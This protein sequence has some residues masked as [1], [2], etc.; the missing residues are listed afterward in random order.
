MVDR[1]TKL[2]W[3]RLV[4][5]R[6]RQVTQIGIKTEDNLEKHLFRRLIRVPKIQRFLLGWLGLF[7]V[8]A[9]G[10]VI[11]LR[12]L[13]STYQTVQPKD[14]G[15][16]TE[17]IIGTFTNANPLYATTTVDSS[18]SRLVFSGLLKYDKNNALVGDLAESW[19]VSP[20]E[21]VYTVKLKD[22]VRW[23]DGAHVTASDVV[24][25]YKMIQNPETKSYLMPS[26][27]GVRVEATDSKTVVF[28]LP[29]SL[30]SFAHSLTTGIIPEHVLKDV[31]PAQLRS[32]SF[33]NTQ[34]IGTGPFM[35]NKV[36]VEGL[37]PE[38]RQERI[39]LHANSN[40]SFGRPK[41]D[42]FVVR[43]YPTEQ[44]LTTAYRDGEVTAML[45]LAQTP[46]DVSQ[47][48]LTQEFTLPLTGEVLV[49][50]KMDQDVLK[51]VNVRKALVA[52]ANKKDIIDRLQYPLVLADS[53]FIKS[54]S[55]YSKV[56]RQKTSTADEAR[57]ILDTAG[58]KLDEKTGIRF[59]DG[60]KLQFRLYSQSTSEYAS[61]TGSLQKQWRDIGVDM[62]VELQNE[63]DLQGTLS[64]HSY[65][66][67][68]YAVSLGTDPDVFAFWHSTQGDPRSS[69]RL[70]FS[71]YKS[72]V[73]DK[74][75]EAGRT[76]SDIQL[77][78]AKYKPFLEAWVA[79]APALA[80][81]QPRFLYVVHK[82]LYGFS[83]TTLNASADRLNNVHEWRVRDG[84]QVK[85]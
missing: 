49:F 79:D 32:V 69:T 28:T 65:D 71:E 21:R 72:P 48:S 70:N 60:K 6:K 63:K 10:L 8:V 50:F 3:R 73:A 45:G 58:W 39:A 20:N 5:R 23:H 81:Y 67:L 40:Y 64:L 46:E 59:K 75:L 52:A 24:F 35:F 53:P 43:T 14:G 76:R 11:Q 74:A 55:T 9:V 41:I 42:N 80:L 33:N 4:R 22:N 62:Q 16:Y 47:D 44:A 7:A 19:S 30:T 61:V 26:W 25:T 13:N 34:P 82:P 36:E 18:V 51:D 83:A 56:I 2:K 27:Q 78:N 37:T 54:Q 85:K 38:E 66:A 29:N 15:T 68:L 1:R 31:K 17:G 57:K 12:A 77:R 84:L